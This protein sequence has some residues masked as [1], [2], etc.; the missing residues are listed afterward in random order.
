MGKR[1]KLL[2]RW[3]TNTPRDAPIDEVEGV[4]D[5]FF[6]DSRAKGRRGSHIVIRDDRL[7]NKGEFGPLGRIEIP[8]K[9]GQRV[10]GIYLERLIRAIDILKELGEQSDEREK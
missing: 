6:G 8:V 4:I 10:K 2:E 5:Y 7:R 9:G 1:D 3:R